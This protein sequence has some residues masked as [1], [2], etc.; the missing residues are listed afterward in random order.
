M[1]ASTSTPWYLAPARPFPAKVWLADR[2]PFRI[3]TPRSAQRQTCPDEPAVP[4][5]R[6]FPALAWLEQRRHL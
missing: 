1:H 6:P 4:P 2:Y 5:R 3:P